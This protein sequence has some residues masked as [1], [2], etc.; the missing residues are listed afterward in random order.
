ML[1]I[2]NLPLNAIGE[3]LLKLYPACRE[4]Q[5]LRE[6]SQTSVS[7]FIYFNTVHDARE[8]YNSSS[9]I[10]Y[11]CRMLSVKFR[12]KSLNI[13]PLAVMKRK[14]N[15]FNDKK[16]FSSS[17]KLKSACDNRRNNSTDEE[18]VIVVSQAQKTN[19]MEEM[20][21]DDVEY[22]SEEEEYIDDFGG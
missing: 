16:D 12:R 8:A 9:N 2:E 18:D 6:K 14:T 13:N 7:A 15:S 5:I 22:K 4:Y 19:H 1:H 10:V 20:K 3:D 11:K 21:E 17:K